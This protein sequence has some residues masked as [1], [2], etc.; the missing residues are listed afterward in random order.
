MIM[1][2]RMPNAYDVHKRYM[3][4]HV[5]VGNPYICICMYVLSLI[6]FVFCFFNTTTHTQTCITAVVHLC[7]CVHTTLYVNICMYV[8]VSSK[9]FNLYIC[10]LL[11][12]FTAFAMWINTSIGLLY[13]TCLLWLH[14]LHYAYW[15]SCSQLRRNRRFSGIWLHL[16]LQLMFWCWQ[17]IAIIIVI[18]HCQLHGHWTDND[19]TALMIAIEKFRRIATTAGVSG[20]SLMSRN[21]GHSFWVRRCHIGRN[22]IGRC[23][24]VYVNHRILAFHILCG[25]VYGQQLSCC[26]LVWRGE[27]LI[28]W[29]HR[30]RHIT[31]YILICFDFRIRICIDL[32]TYADYVLRINSLIDQCLQIFWRQN[33]C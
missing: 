31:F 28:N 5:H 2:I 12:L 11:C 9:K 24:G 6:P 17:P 13:S 20:C 3:Y 27:W 18:G 33:W 16:H 23:S 10:M 8:Y 32:I 29:G 30:H 7:G 19:A 22:C 21:G 1:I 4:V 14:L 26:G 25:R 15:V